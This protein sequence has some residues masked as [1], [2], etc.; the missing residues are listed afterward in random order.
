MGARL[1]GKVGIVTGAG[2]GMGA[3]HALALAQEGADVAAVDICHDISGIPYS[4]ATERKLNEVVDEVKKL[5]RRAIGIKCDISKAN[6]VERMVKIVIETF[7][8]VDI[9]V[10]N[11]AVVTHTDFTELTEELWDLVMDVNLK[12]TFLCCKYV[13]PH[14]IAQESGKIVNIGSTS[15]RVPDASLVHYSTAKAGVH[16]FTDALSK[17]VAKHNIHVNCV[18]PGA[19]RR[20]QMHEWALEAF[21]QALGITP[22]EFYKR[23]LE[24][25]TTL[26]QEITPEDVANAMLF[27]ASEE[28]RNLTGYVIYVDGGFPGYRF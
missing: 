7:G 21:G 2:H 23:E 3:A 27:L 16:M 26:K 25:L 28:S 10:N 24:A 17:A 1:E 6:E 4:M 8:K 12:G 20:T 14:M 18:A 15:G 19:V 9:L 22:E 13:I 11:A 5:E